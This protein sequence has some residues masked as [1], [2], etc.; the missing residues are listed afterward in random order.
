MKVIV[1]ISDMQVPYHDKRALENIIHFV[2]DFKPTEVVTVGDEMDMQ[3]IS[4]WSKG[5]KLEYEGSI[6]RDRDETCS[7]MER[8]G[9]SHMARSNHTDRLFN[10]VSL[11]APGL[12]GL[13]ELNIQNFFRMD[14]LGI[15]YHEDPYELAPDW[16]LMHGD[17]GSA[18]STAGQ[19]ALGLAKRTGTSIICG[20]THRQAIIPYSQSHASSGGGII[21]KTIYGFETGNVMDYRKARYIKGGLFNWQQG[22]GILY[23]DGK[24]VTPVAVPI[25]RDGSFIV[26]GYKWG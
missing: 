25:Q 23:V 17:E 24:T 19:T 26:N 2:K 16:L 13:P 1:A 8:L 12:L 15:K 10:T 5:T 4:K 20:H 9:V 21:S 11:R 3:T 7:I 18:N 22:F 6:G 14:D